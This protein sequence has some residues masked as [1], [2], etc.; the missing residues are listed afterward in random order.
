MCVLVLIGLTLSNCCE[1]Q[2]ALVTSV[3]AN[4]VGVGAIKNL[5]NFVFLYVFA[6]NLVIHLSKAQR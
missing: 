6:W 2:W 5:F 3:E 1:G 4:R